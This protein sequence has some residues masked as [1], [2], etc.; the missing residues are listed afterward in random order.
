MTSVRLPS[1]PPRIVLAFLIASIAGCTTGGGSGSGASS[2]S[3]GTSADG[4]SSSGSSGNGS[5][6]SGGNGET[7]TLGS[8]LSASPTSEYRCSDGYPIQTN[9]TFPQP[10]YA[11]GSGSC[12]LLT[13]LPPAAISPGSGTAVSADI[14][15]GATTGPMR[16]VKMR[17]L[18][19]NGVGPKCCSLQEYG[20]EFTPRA[21][22][23]TTVPLGFAMLEEHVPPATDT[24][25]IIANDLIALEVLAP[26]V[27]IP[28]H[29]PANGGPVT[30]IAN[31]LWLPALSSVD[32]PAPSNVL[33]QHTGSFSGFVPLF[34][35]AYVPS[36]T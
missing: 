17:I 19:Q 9:P 2:S 24:T 8:D 26:N 7:L 18:Y 32:T 34:S 6:S 22:A 3:G 16:F 20:E 14:K 33:L 28:G 21:N 30:N 13:F 11:S 31:Y 15:V 25:T 1:S 23:T 10:F 27:P 5:S 4:G 12:T 35:I 29:W 36:G